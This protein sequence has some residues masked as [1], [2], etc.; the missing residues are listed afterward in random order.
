MRLVLPLAIGK[1]KCAAE[2]RTKSYLAL[3]LIVSKRN[4]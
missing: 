1:V 3:L 2:C 4:N